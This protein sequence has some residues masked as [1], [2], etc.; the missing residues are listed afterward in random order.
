[1]IAL[2]LFTRHQRMPEDAYLVVGLGN[3][4]P[5]YAGHRH[6]VGYRVAD[7]LRD[8][9]GATWK[10]DR[11]GRAQVVEGRLRPGGP[12]VVL[13]RA[14]GYMNESGAPVAR[15]LAFYRLPVERLV[16]V[17]DELDLPFDVVRVKVGGGAGG[18]NGV[19]SVMA[20]VGSGDFLRVRLGIGRPPGSQD[21]A[22]F[23]LSDYSVTESKLLPL[24][25]EHAADV[26]ES[27]VE[28]G[29]LRTQSV[30]NR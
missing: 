19:R 22:D 11:S 1:V 7:V 25:V 8:R 13:G 20:S 27:I 24:Q 6:S 4:G 2:R 23:V 12:R 28:I 30:F 3:P 16:V 18:H 5:R 17:H 29:P 26:V 15:L 10:S 14:R 9:L 21:A